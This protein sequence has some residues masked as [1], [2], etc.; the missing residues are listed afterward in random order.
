[1][2]LE[3]WPGAWLSKFPKSTEDEIQALI[4]IGNKNHANCPVLIVGNEVLLRRDLTEDELIADIQLVKK[5]TGS[6]V[7]MPDRDCLLDPA[8]LLLIR[9][10]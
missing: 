1:L 10:N 6:K 7:L 2:N 3:C 9:S 8:S 4:D 5:K